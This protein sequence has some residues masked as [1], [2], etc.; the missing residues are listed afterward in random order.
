MGVARFGAFFLSIALLCPAAASAEV[1]IDV[2]GASDEVTDAVRAASLLVSTEAEDAETVQD[3]VAAARADYGRLVAVMYERG[4]FGPEI[5]IRLNGQEAATLSPFSPP[6][7]ITSMEI[8]VNPG[9]AFRLGRAEIAPL[10]PDTDLP[11]GFRSGAPAGTPILRETAEAAITGWRNDGHAIAD[12]TRQSITARQPEGVLDAEITVAPGPLIRF[13]DLIPEGQD[14]MRSERIRE[15]AGLPRGEVFSP[16]AVETTETRLRRTGVFRS[17]ALEERP[18]GA[19][20]T[21]DIGA[22]LVEAPLRR[23]GFGAELSSTDGAALSTYWLHRNL[24]GGAERLRFDAEIRGISGDSGGADWEL[25]G[26]FSRPATINADTTLVFDVTLAGLDEPNFEETLFEITGGFERIYSDTLT[27]EIGLGLRYSDI[28]DAFGS[29]DVTLLTLPLGL[30]FDNRD[31]PLDAREGYFA[32][33]ELTPFA[34]LDG[35]VDGGGLRATLDARGYLALGQ[36]DRHRLAGR[37]QLGTVEGGDF[38]DLPPEFLF[39][40]GGGDTVRGQPY[41]S[42][43][44]LQGGQVAGGRGFLG[45]S[46]E[47]RADITDTYGLV[48]FVDGGYISGE[49]LWDD[50]GDWQTGAGLGLRYNT[51]LGPIRV[52]LATPVSGDDAGQSLQLYIGIGHAF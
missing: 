26:A 10:A 24:F 5:S 33:L 32:E 15:I 51:A 42:L 8:R 47:Y 50:S 43:G 48:V 6:A 49:A 13:G 41:Q 29:R 21:M 19:D 16:A 4:F 14:R 38:T 37:L 27:G 44:A 39:F 36:S 40:S 20:D 17:V 12:I 31:D 52:D 28:T 2:P 11:E 3:L 34:V 18:P 30:T 45:L 7:Q 22:T 23:F 1:R 46:A 25:G 9:R 35:S